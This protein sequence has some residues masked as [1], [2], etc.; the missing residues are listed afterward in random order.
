M[1]R[2]KRAGHS[3]LHGGNRRPWPGAPGAL[4]Q[5]GLHVAELLH[6]SDQI[7]A[8]V[9]QIDRTAR[10]EEDDLDQG[11]LEY[12]KPRLRSR[13]SRPPPSSPCSRRARAE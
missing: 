1:C 2:T 4:A 5:E 12:V 9:A 8:K 7:S 6:L 13:T 10:E 11:G 3:L